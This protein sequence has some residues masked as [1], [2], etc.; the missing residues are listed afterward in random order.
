MTCYTLDG[1]KTFACGLTQPAGW[2]G[3]PDCYLHVR[4][5]RSG[6]QWICVIRGN[7]KLD[8]TKLVRKWVQAEFGGE[9]SLDGGIMHRLSGDYYARIMTDGREPESVVC[10]TGGGFYLKGVAA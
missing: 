6:E 10:W 8:L 9:L 3:W 1:W 2:S 5:E 4:E 7:E